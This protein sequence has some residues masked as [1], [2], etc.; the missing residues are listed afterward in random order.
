LA[1]IS[2]NS[3][4]PCALQQCELSKCEIFIGKHLFNF[5]QIATFMQCM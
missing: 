1:G 2:E 3:W 4:Q 5:T